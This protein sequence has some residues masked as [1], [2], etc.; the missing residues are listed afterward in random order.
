MQSTGIPQ[1]QI[2]SKRAKNLSKIKNVISENFHKPAKELCDHTEDL[3]HL[4]PHGRH[5]WE[6]YFM[7]F[8]HLE[9]LGSRF[10]KLVKSLVEK[11]Y[12]RHH[13]KTPTPLESICKDASHQMREAIFNCRLANERIVPAKGLSP[14]QLLKISEAL[15]S[16][17]WHNF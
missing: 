7:I 4:D 2:N 14:I 6:Q 13:W 9:K 17:R 12:L 8:T 11:K 10:E 3:F 16:P 15:T 1:T 5:S